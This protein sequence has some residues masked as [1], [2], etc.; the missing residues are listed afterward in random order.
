MTRP[1]DL[2]AASMQA[3]ELVREHPEWRDLIRLVTERLRE[4]RPARA[5]AVRACRG[6]ARDNEGAG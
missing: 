4:L 1:I 2:T 3:E 6:A 5:G